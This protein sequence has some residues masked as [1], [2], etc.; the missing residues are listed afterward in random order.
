[1]GSHPT[2][3]QTRRHTDTSHHHTDTQCRMLQLCVI[4]VL[5]LHGRETSPV[6]QDTQ[7]LCVQLYEDEMYQER[8]WEMSLWSKEGIRIL[9]GGEGRSQ[10]EE[11]SEKGRI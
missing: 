2:T 10:G 9:T 3:S 1:M 8:G 7:W 11:F 4:L 5:L 6:I